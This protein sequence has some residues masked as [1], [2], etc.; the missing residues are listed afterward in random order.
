MRHRIKI[1]NFQDILRYLKNFWRYLKNFWRYLELFSTISRKIFRPNLGIVV[2]EP[3]YIRLGVRVRVLILVQL[4]F[5]SSR[6]PKYEV[7]MSLQ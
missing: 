2:S 4:G 6:P 1:R 3:M 5:T 7:R